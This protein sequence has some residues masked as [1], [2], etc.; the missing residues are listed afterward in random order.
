[1]DIV[2]HLGKNENSKK[3]RIKTENIS[4][5][6]STLF[7]AVTR[8]TINS[9]STLAGRIDL[10]ISHAKEWSEKFF[11]ATWMAYNMDGIEKVKQ[12]R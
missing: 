2:E 9:C 10:Y 3:N 8:V 11:H 1:M 12:S 6:L 5:L 7:V 4:L